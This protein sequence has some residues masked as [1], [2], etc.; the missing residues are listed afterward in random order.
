[1]EVNMDN[2]AIQQISCGMF[3]LTALDGTKQNGCIINTAMQVTSSPLQISVT[4]NK[5]NYTTEIISKT[6][7]FNLSCIDESADFELFKR[8]GFASGRD[9]DKFLGFSDCKTAA[10]GIRYVTKGTN[11]YMSAKVVQTIDVGTHLI[12]IGEITQAQMLSG[13]PSAT[14]GYYHKNIK[15]APPQKQT[16]NTTK[17][18]WVCKVCGYVYEGDELPNGYIC[19]LCKH[20]ASDFEKM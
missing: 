14:Y 1:M 13:N 4:V 8:F 11:S 20:P 2:K 19:P 10:N 16:Q 3:V 15:P 5:S 6:G 12:F 17:T 18:K 9:T 7:A